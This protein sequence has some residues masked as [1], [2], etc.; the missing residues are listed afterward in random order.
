MLELLQIIIIGMLLILSFIYSGS[1]VALFSIPEFEFRKLSRQKGRNAARLMHYLRKPQQA[2]I[3]IL[4]GNMV[5]NSSASI[6]GEHLS[7]S[8]FQSNSL[9]FSVFIMT[10][11][12]LL[13]G[14]ILPKNFAVTRPIQFSR[15]FIPLLHLTNRAF[16][17]VQFIVQLMVRKSSGLSKRHHLTK[18]ELLSAV[19]SG[20][21][22]GIHYTSIDA[23]SNLI[24]LINRPISDIMIP[25]AEIRGIDIHDYWSNMESL[26]SENP[27]STVLF[28]DDTI[29]HI[30]GYIKVTEFIHSNKKDIRGNLVKPLFVPEAKH[31]LPLL[32]D[33]K[34]NQ[35]FMAIVLD[36]FGGTSGIV[37]LKDILDAIFLRD[38]FLK[39]CIQKMDTHRWSIRGDTKLSD[40]NSVLDL[41]LPIESN[42]IGGYIV[43]VLG[44]IPSVGDEMKL[45]EGFTVRIV[46]RSPKQIEAVEFQKS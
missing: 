23:L 6:L 21:E 9:F 33:F 2:L 34:K 31:I 28:Y 8:F 32:S 30:L 45:E 14:E 12:L 20:T 26:V 46:E 1:E 7:K 10:F 17:P 11:L 18:D 44:E 25:R 27:F 43:N 41:N 36:E 40:I 4:I 37:T 3:T 39:Q 22:A 35:N 42:T 24:H 13:F 16:F 19:E 29:D 38:I 15:R 5:A